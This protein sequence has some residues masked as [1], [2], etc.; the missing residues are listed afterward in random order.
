MGGSGLGSPPQ[1]H[2]RPRI[3]MATG[4]Q[5]HAR[6]MCSDTHHLDHVPARENGHLVVDMPLRNGALEGV[7]KLVDTCQSQLSISEYVHKGVECGVPP[8]F[9]GRV[10]WYAILVRWHLWPPAIAALSLSGCEPTG[11]AHPP[12]ALKANVACS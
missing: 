1:R 8:Q 6:M 9:S 5:A 2:F 4:W 10:H 3:E 11:G 7:M 12:L